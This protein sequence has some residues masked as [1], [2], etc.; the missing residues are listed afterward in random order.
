MC[1]KEYEKGL[2]WLLNGNESLGGEGLATFLLPMGV[3]MARGVQ[4]LVPSI[5]WKDA[6]DWAQLTTAERRI[7]RNA[8]AALGANHAQILDLSAKF[9]LN[10]TGAWFGLETAVKQY[11]R[12]PVQRS[13]LDSMA[14]RKVMAH[15]STPSLLGHGHYHIAWL[16]VADT[17]RQEARGAGRSTG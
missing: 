15:S 8:H 11:R 14:M 13:Y 17:L 16:I 7:C 1:R 6:P 10:W 2:D 3:T 12:L 4:A 5:R 9:P